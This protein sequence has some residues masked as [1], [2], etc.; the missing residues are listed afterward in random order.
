LQYLVFPDGI[1]YNRQKDETRTQRVNEV[2]SAM[3]HLASVSEKEKPNFSC[4]KL[5][6][7][8]W[9]GGAGVKSKYL[10]GDLKLVEWYGG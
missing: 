4:E 6:L 1:I 10:R 2:F 5:G 3:A 7:T 8:G 9:V